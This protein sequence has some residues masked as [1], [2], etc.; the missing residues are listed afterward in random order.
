MAERYGWKPEGTRKS[1]YEELVRGLESG[2]LRES[3]NPD[4]DGYFLND[5]NVVSERDALALGRA[6]ELAALLHPQEASLLKR[7]SAV[8]LAGGFLIG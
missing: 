5:W 8:A 2:P 6:L 7:L 4:R 1:N 3:G